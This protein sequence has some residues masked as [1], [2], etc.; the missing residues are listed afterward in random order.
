ME[1]ANDQIG[2]QWHVSDAA[3]EALV[4]LCVDICQRN[5]ALKN[6]LNYTGDARGNLTKHSYFTSTACPGPYLGG[7]F[8]WLA[9]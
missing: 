2:G 5:P 3:L 8:S 4:K 9:E 7:K 1:V 6:G